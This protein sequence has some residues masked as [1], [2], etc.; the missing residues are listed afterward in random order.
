[1]R[2]RM[3][4]TRATENR[5]IVAYINLVG[6]QDEL[7][8][9]G[10]SLVLDPNGE[11]IARGAQ[12]EEDLIVADLDLDEVFHLRLKDPQHRQDTSSVVTKTVS[13]PEPRRIKK[14][15][16]NRSRSPLLD[17]DGEIYD[18][19]RIYAGP[20][21]VYADEASEAAEKYAEES[22]CEGDYTCI[23]GSPMTLFVR[24]ASAGKDA[25]WE[26]FEVTGETEP[27]Y[28]ARKKEKS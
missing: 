13:V 7:V 5:A 28:T 8:F 14:P 19:G 21:S 24:L 26:R 1:L 18:D 23:Q 6:A 2:E 16:P 27:V 3:L 4:T 10:D 20:P 12:F 11:I 15:L 25:P 22:D 17:E 9:D